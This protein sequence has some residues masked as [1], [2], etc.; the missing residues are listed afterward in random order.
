MA[1]VTPPSIEIYHQLSPERWEE[2][3]PRPYRRGP[4]EVDYWKGVVQRVYRQLD[5]L[6]VTQLAGHLVSVIELLRLR[7]ALDTPAAQARLATD[8]S[9]GAGL[10][11]RALVNLLL[12]YIEDDAQD[13]AKRSVRH[14]SEIYLAREPD[15]SEDHPRYRYSNMQ[16]NR[17]WRGVGGVQERP[18]LP[19]YLDQSTDLLLHTVDVVANRLY[20]NWIDLV[21][22]TLSSFSESPVYRA[23]VE[24]VLRPEEMRLYGAVEV[25]PGLGQGTV[26]D[27]VAHHLYD[28]IYRQK[29]LIFDYVE[30]GEAHS[31]LS[32]LEEHLFLPEI[33]SSI[34][35]ATLDSRRQTEFQLRWTEMLQCAR[36]VVDT[37]LLSMYYTL[38]NRYSRTPELLETGVLRLHPDLV[39]LLDDVDEVDLRDPRWSRDSREG[40]ARLPVEEIWGFLGE[41]LAQYRRGWYYHSALPD[42]PPLGTVEVPQWE[43]SHRVTVKNVYNLAKSLTHAPI[44]GEYLPLPR[45][46]TSLS[47]DQRRAYLSRWVSGGG[48]W[49]DISG[50][51]R[52]LYP[53]LP[54]AALPA[55]HQALL[56]TLRPL[57]LRAVFQS[58]IYHGQLTHYRPTPAITDPLY[59]PNKSAQRQA[60]AR[61]LTSEVRES[62]GEA[63]YWLHG[64]PYTEMAVQHREGKVYDWWTGLSQEWIWSTTYAMNWISQ[65]AFYHRYLHQRVLL[66]TGSTGVGKSTQVP[67]LLLYG[68]LAFSYRP[69]G[70]VVCTQPRIQPTEANARTV[71]SELGVPIDQDDPEGGTRPT[72]DYLVQYQHSGASHRRE[73]GPY[74]RFLTD[75]SLLAD[76]QRRPLLAREDPSTSHLQYLPQN[77]YDVVIIDE[78]HE[79]NANMDIILTLARTATGVNNSLRLVI[80]SATMEADEPRYRRYYRDINDNLA[81]PL[82]RYLAEC[83]LDRANLDRRIHI[84]PPGATTQFRITDVFLSAEEAA[85]V[86]P[87]NYLARGTALTINVA[88]TTAVG[89]LLY[90][91]PGKREIL[92]AVEEINQ[93]TAPHVIA[94]PYYRELG[95]FGREVV[96]SIHTQLPLYT[97]R[98]ADIMLPEDQIT[99]RVSPGTYTRAIIVA[100]NIA[101]ASIT[102]KNLRYV[103]D[104]G[105]AKSRVYDPVTGSYRMVTER[106]SQSSSTQRRG[107]VGRVADGTVYY[108]YSATALRD[109]ATVFKIAQ[110]NPVGLLGALGSPRGATPLYTR[111]EDPSA[112]ATWRHPPSFPTTLLPLLR[113]YYQYGARHPGPDYPQWWGCE[114]SGPPDFREDHDDYRSTAPGL[115]QLPIPQTSGYPLE[116]V[117]DRE[118]TFY[119]VHPDEDIIRRRGLT[120]EII[121]VCPDQAV[122]PEYADLLRQRGQPS[123]LLLM[124]V[125]LEEEG[126]LETS[127]RGLHLTRRWTDLSAAAQAL[128][129]RVERYQDALWVTSL[130]AEPSEVWVDA[131]ALQILLGAGTVS[132][133]CPAFRIPDV[134]DL[135]RRHRDREGDLHWMWRVWTSLREAWERDPIWQR[136]QSP[137]LTEAEYSQLLRAYHRQGEGLSRAEYLVLSRLDE[138]GQLG[139]PEGRAMYQRARPPPTLAEI[140][141]SI[142]GVVRRW[143]LDPRLTLDA[144]RLILQARWRAGTPSAESEAL[145][146]Q[147]RPPSTV[148]VTDRWGLLRAAYLASRPGQVLSTGRQ[149]RRLV[150]RHRDGWQLDTPVWSIRVP[151]PKTWWPGDSQ[152]LLYDQIE[153]GHGTGR[154]SPIWLT[155]V[156][157]PELERL[158][159]RKVDSLAPLR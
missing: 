104:T 127:D 66:V 72:S 13:S 137:Q 81:Y 48:G 120:G 77:V 96:M 37:I 6:A 87:D 151:L 106:I 41:Q 7:W 93:Q 39:H 5:P 108:L 100:T 116:E 26:Y 158:R 83:R 117:I 86:T 110:D 4:G 61:S 98:K 76:Y 85:Q 88:N 74:L 154:G 75:G 78:A 119:L 92:Q 91:L 73:E 3:V 140:P 150:Y 126:M 20:V 112:V 152:Y 133:W 111:E 8:L 132:D 105:Y 136:A 124:A 148:L 156:S 71:A 14:L 31:Y 82:A 42:A 11:E 53:D 141:V 80:V 32:Y 95:E 29:W 16:Y 17:C 57:L 60:L 49:W 22:V 47:G 94:L 101:E 89:D 18:L 45:P 23:T 34:E 12:P 129:L 121:G 58:L 149:D 52:R 103:I 114:G 38:V 46:W 142:A 123:K 30:D 143:G 33:W 25:A 36:T 55:V 131:L 147:L 115:R 62:Y 84:S 144:L 15:S 65:L 70:R 67:K 28:E 64:R 113:V 68:L 138:E 118:G 69:D 97:R 40:L 109:S 157:L 56:D 51:L 90:F 54:R 44:E 139:T 99:L 134:K 2:L 128:A 155:P 19:V 146:R 63:F 130:V 35:W 24:S 43:W 159:P 135:R 27:V 122:G 10:G 1:T 153:M 145:G 59:A 125:R 107:R 21:P 102:I 9:Q 50:Y 79:H